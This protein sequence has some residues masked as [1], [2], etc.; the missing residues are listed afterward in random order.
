MKYHFACTLI[1]ILL[2][3]CSANKTIKDNI[4]IDGFLLNRGF[5]KILLNRNSV[6]H[7]I[8]T[9]FYDD[10]P[11]KVI[12]DTGA[13][14]TIF[15]IDFVRSLNVPLEQA[16]FTGGGVG[17]SQAQVFQMPVK[18]I[19]IGT[20]V[21]RHVQPYAMSIAHINQALTERNSDKV[22]G[23]LGSDILTAYHAII[24]YKNDHLYL[25]NQSSK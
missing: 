3:T 25:L 9:V 10:N 20:L 11:F 23:V 2:V 18:K 8:L 17:T 15:D 5:Q 1:Y 12:L 13:S 4:M 14:S 24:D 21:I 16:T 22:E 19:R 7:F 6:G